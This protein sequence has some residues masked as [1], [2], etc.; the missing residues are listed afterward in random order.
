MP[1]NA[2]ETSQGCADMV[3]MS[4]TELAKQRGIRKNSLSECVSR[5]EAQ[6]LIS[7]KRGHGKIKLIN[8]AEFERAVSQG[9]D[10]GREQG[11]RTRRQDAGEPASASYTREQT[12]KMAYA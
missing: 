5:L 11:N 8:V 9:A 1:N 7:T 10:L 2:E 4:V 12:R 6:G 3:W